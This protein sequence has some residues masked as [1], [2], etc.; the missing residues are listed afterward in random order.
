MSIYFYF[1]EYL[2][3]NLRDLKCLRS[4]TSEEIVRAQMLTEAKVTSLKFLIFFEPWL[5]FI[6]GK[7]IRG[8]L[9]DFESWN[10]PTDYVFKP[11]SSKMFIR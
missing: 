10:L 8:Q 7:L 5:P 6:D 2:N 11:V 3:C 4:K 1:G 9:L